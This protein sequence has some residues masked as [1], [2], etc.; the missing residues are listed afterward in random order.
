M[1]LRRLS[2]RLSYSV[3]LDFTLKKNYLLSVFHLQLMAGFVV[4]KLDVCNASSNTA[5]MGTSNLASSSILMALLFSNYAIDNL[6]AISKCAHVQTC[7]CLVISC[8]RNVC[9]RYTVQT[10]AY[11]TVTSRTTYT[12]TTTSCG[13]FGWGR[14]DTSRSVDTFQKKKHTAETKQLLSPSERTY[15]MM[16]I[17]P[18]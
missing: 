7:D 12:H 15:Q 16:T 8:R 9:I 4:S 1:E 18:F 5:V 11:Y 3:T 13:W 17:I 2:A 10:E 14:C 6:Q